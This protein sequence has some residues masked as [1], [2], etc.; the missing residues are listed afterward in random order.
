MN[1]KLVAVLIILALCV[2]TIFAQGGKE[3]EGYVIGSDCTW[4]PLEYVDENGDIVGFEIDLVAAISDYSGVPL[5]IKNVAWDGIFAGLSNGAY[6]AVVSGV[7]ILEERKK[8]MDF[9]IPVL[10][11]TQSILVQSSQTEISSTA[12]LA[13]KTVGVQIG[14]TGQFA[15]ESING[16]TI[17]SYDEIGL[18]VQDLLNDNLDAVVADSIIASDF[19]LANEN[20]KGKL[21]VTGDLGGDK[22][23][24]G[25][26]VKKGDTELLELLNDGIKAMMD[27][28]TVDEL[29]A[30][31]NIL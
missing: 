26:A 2:T 14:T 20:Y 11:I 24:I 17:K 16:V 22:E 15:L 6:D 8:A 7:T 5:K 13:G 18:A 31:Y 21:T 23:Q 1:K 9:T 25:F 10:E 27:D 29:K 28:G 30:K 4:P 3:T 12:D 19:V